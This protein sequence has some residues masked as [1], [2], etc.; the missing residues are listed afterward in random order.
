MNSGKNFKNE[1]LAIIGATFLILLVEGTIIFYIVGYL[2]KQIDATKEKQRLLSVAKIERFNAVYLKN[3]LGKVENYFSVVNDIL[4]DEKNI[5]S[6]ISQIEAIGQNTGNK[7]SVQVD[8]S[9]IFADSTTGSR[10]VIFT[11]PI[12]G[13]YQSIRQ[14]LE[15]LNSN[16]FFAKINSFNFSGSPTI[17]NVSSGSLSGEIY[18]K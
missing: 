4:P 16:L 18:L 11:A 12:S 7:V 6:A 3:D 8:S 10:Y 13:N 9:Q 17:N 15:N 5:L 2:Q 14:Y 1:I